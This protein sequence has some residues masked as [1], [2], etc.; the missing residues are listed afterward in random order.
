ML[1]YTKF[2]PSLKGFD[3]IRQWLPRNKL[4]LLGVDSKSDQSKLAE[5][6]RPAVRKNVEAA[7]KRALLHR[8]KVTGEIPDSDDDVVMEE[9]PKSAD[10]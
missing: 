6:K 9:P 10:S 4:E 2:R 1:S 3:F 8:S 5:G 7:F